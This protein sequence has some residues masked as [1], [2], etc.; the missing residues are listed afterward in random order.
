MQLRANCLGQA[1]STMK[2]HILASSGN[3][4]IPQQIINFSCKNEFT[5]IATTHEKKKINSL[6]YEQNTIL[7][8]QM[9]KKRTQKVTTSSIN[10]MA[11]FST[12]HLSWHVVTQNKC[13]YFSLI[14]FLYVF[15]V[16]VHILMK[17][18]SKDMRYC[19]KNVLSF[20]RTALLD[21]S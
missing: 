6:R 9:E 7:I 5:P 8:C 20:M 18:Y 21:V 10:L 13:L 12:T 16:L 19:Y 3:Y 1:V 2:H 17:Y 11:Q 4:L 15:Y 14:A